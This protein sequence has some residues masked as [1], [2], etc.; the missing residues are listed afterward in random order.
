M[1]RFVCP[2]PDSWASSVQFSSVVQSCPA[3]CGPMDCSTPGFP[4]HHQLPEFTQTHGHWVGDATQPSHPSP[5]A[6]SLS[7]H[8]GL[9][10]WV[11]SSHLVAKYWSFSFIISPSKEYSGSI[12][13]FFFSSFIYFF[14]LQYCIGFAIHWHESAMGEHVFSILNPPPTSLPIPSLWVIPVHQPWAPCLM[15]WTWT[16]DSFHIHVSMPFSHIT[17]PSPSPTESKRL[18]YTSVSLL[19]SRIQD[20]RYHPS[21]F[22]VYTL[23]YCIGL[24]LSGL[25]HS[26]KAPVSS[27]SLELIQ[28]YSF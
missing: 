9:F 14:T 24:F 21:K 8:Q 15:H 16:G 19:L 2:S 7:Q 27:T 20:Y 23:V 1:P 22:H 13:F 5:P 6:F 17:L 28:M 12:S 11:S 18:F 25:L 4:V 26:V 3:L 10:K